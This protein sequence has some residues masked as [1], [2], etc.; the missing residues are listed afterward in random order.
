MQRKRAFIAIVVI[1][2]LLSI[3]LLYAQPIEITEYIFNPGQVIF[4]GGWNR[5]PLIYL[6]ISSDS[7]NFEYGK[8]AYQC[9]IPPNPG[10]YTV[11]TYDFELI[12]LNIEDATITIRVIRQPESG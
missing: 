10:N 11:G 6:G 1:A 12:R 3:S 9:V 5:Q 7:I 2:S 8:K 4:Q